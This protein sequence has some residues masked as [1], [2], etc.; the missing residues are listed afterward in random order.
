MSL[1]FDGADD[2]SVHGSPTLLDN[3]TQSA[4]GVTITMWLYRTGDGTN[5]AG[6]PSRRIF[7]KGTIF[8]FFLNTSGA[9]VA[10]AFIIQEPRATTTRQ[11][12]TAAN[13]LT[14]NSVW[15]FIAITVAPSTNATDMHIYTALA[16]ATG[17]AEATYSSSQNGS[18]TVTDDSAV[19]FWI[20]GEAGAGDRSFQGRIA[21]FRIW[22]NRIL[23]TS[24]IDAVFRGNHLNPDFYIPFWTNGADLSG[25][26]NNGTLTGTT[27]DNHPPLGRYAL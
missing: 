11:R 6:V 10:S 2:V 14:A 20:G 21:D 19:N 25:N 3:L 22:T 26:A 12:V 1:L 4:N 5:A 15:H 18:G 27:V 23:T 9:G 16:S 17:V 24:E 7:R 8:G 13:T